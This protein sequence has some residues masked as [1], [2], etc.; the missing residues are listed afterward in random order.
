VANFATED[1]WS[2]C[3]RVK[4]PLCAF[5]EQD[6]NCKLLFVMPKEEADDVVPRILAVQEVLERTRP[7]GIHLSFIYRFEPPERIAAFCT[8]DRLSGT[9]EALR[10][11]FQLEPDGDWR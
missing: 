3:K 6:G 11:I 2:I 5:V 9:D 7:A 1:I 4:A 8:V 10:Q